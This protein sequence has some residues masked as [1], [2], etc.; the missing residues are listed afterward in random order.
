MDYHLLRDYFEHPSK[1][2]AGISWNPAQFGAVEG[3][4]LPVDAVISDIGFFNAIVPTHSCGGISDAQRYNATTNPGGVRCDIADLAINVFGPRAST[5]WTAA[6]RKV[7][8]GFAGVAVDNVGVVYGLS[9]L[10]AGVITPGEF[11]DLNAKIGGLDP[12]IV[13]TAARITADEP[14]L[15]NAYRSGMINEANNLNQTAIIDCR[16]PDPGA[17]HDAYRAFA[18]RARLDREHGNH[19]NQLIWE[20][21]A[22][23]VGDTQCNVLSLQ[24]M[25]RWL[26]AVTDDHSGKSMAARIAGDRPAGLG[27]EC[28]SGIGQKLSDGLCGDTVVPVY[29]TPRTVAGDALTTDDNT[30]QLKPLRR[31]D[32]AVTFTDAQWATL[33]ATFPNGVCDFSKPGVSQQ[34]TIPWMTYQDSSGHVVYGGR[35]MRAAPSSATCRDR[36]MLTVR[37]PLAH[38]AARVYV[39][40][41]RIRILRGRAARR[42]VR[43][44]RFPAGRVIVTVRAG[45]RSR[46]TRFNVCTAHA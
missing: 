29:G 35:A 8:H 41:R 33:N 39:N 3:N 14:A 26:G 17:A 40:G 11:V 5:S 24:A 30:C 43:I 4:L 12:D 32:Y 19:A 13:P 10:K 22:P 36:R 9:A 27:D 44:T 45:T 1:W 18:V 23:I 25:D 16:G 6:E 2:G 42:P 38:A 7:G 31:G 21:P 28:L 20:G 15:A 46:S 34:P 37:P